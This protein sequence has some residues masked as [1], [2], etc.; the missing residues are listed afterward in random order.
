MQIETI[1]TPEQ[2]ETALSIFEVIKSSNSI[3]LHCHPSPDPDSLGSAL[4]TKFALESI[5]KKVTIISG[6]SSIPKGFYHFPGAESVL[7]QNYG[8]TDLSQFDLF[9]IQDT[10]SLE[11]ISRKAPVVFPEHLKTVV[12]DHHASN[13]GFAQ[14]NIVAIQYPSTTEILFDL[15]TLWGIEFSHDMA[16]N[17]YIGLFTDTGGFR[18]D[19][20]TK[21]SFAMASTLVELA[22]D[23]IEAIKIMENSS[24]EGRINFL[25]LALSQKKVFKFNESESAGVSADGTDLGSF[26]ISYISHADVTRLGLTPD[27]WSG[28]EISYILRS[29]VGWNVSCLLIEATPGESKASFRTRDQVKFDVSKVALALGGGGHKA[30]AGAVVSLPALEA[31]EKVAE[32]IKLVLG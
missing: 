19:R 2:K 3:L 6:D 29:V 8:Q 26:V 24:S 14:Q 20:V 27:D 18:Y 11:M 32:T 9:I 22:P 25:G 12:I 5:G 15:F 23:M 4:A 31:V 13:K 30:A 28:S 16:V 1:L 17:L 21:H 7:N 10:G